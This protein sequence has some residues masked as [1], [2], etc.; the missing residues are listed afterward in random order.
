MKIYVLDKVLEYSNNKTEIDKLFSEIDRII[1]ESKYIFSHLE[2]GG[3]EIYDGFYEYFL[4]NIKSIQEVKVVVKTFKEFSRDILKTTASYLENAIPEIQILSDE[5][6]KSPTRES[7][8]RLADLIEGI[9]WI[10]DI[11]VIVDKSGEIE[12]IV[13]SYEIWNQYAKDI[14][15][16]RELIDEFEEVLQNEDLVSIADILSYEIGPLFEKMLGKLNALVYRDLGSIDFS[17]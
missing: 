8:E 16:L 3:V 4:E 10:M 1:S 5:F 14:Y 13:K 12:N 17:S 11:F 9:K 2:I 15:S 6:Y 7:W